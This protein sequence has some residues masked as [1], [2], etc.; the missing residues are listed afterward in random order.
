MDI[1]RRRRILGTAMAI[2]GLAAEGAAQQS[3]PA[4]KLPAN[5]DRLISISTAEVKRWAREPAVVRAVRE[6]NARKESMADIHRVDKEWVSAP[7][8][9]GLMKSLLSNPC[10][11]RLSQLQKLNPAY[12]KTFVFDA[13]GA[14]VC[15][16]IRT[17]D[18]WQGD[19]DKW[20][21][22]VPLGNDAVFVDKP[23]YDPHLKATVV[24]ISTTISDEARPV[25]GLT[26]T[27]D[28][29]WLTKK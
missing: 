28:L 1:G 4:G 5:Y 8:L 19:E 12:R 20:A 16:T 3:P 11:Q 13:Q 15:M 10:A 18:Y 26:A 9:T 22:T 27:I 23:V 29:D 17:D 24:Q 6:K 25:G 14:N 21:K 7:E 2:A